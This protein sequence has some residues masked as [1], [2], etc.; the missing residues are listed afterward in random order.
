MT[1]KTHVNA[2]KTKIVG[3]WTCMY[4]VHYWYHFIIFTT[5]QNRF[6]W[7]NLRKETQNLCIDSKVHGEGAHPINGTF[8]KRG[9]DLIKLTYN[10]CGR[11]LTASTINWDSTPAVQ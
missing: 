6:F 9:L 10:P 11:Q 8:S 2:N 5:T 1:I 3:H 7:N 4:M